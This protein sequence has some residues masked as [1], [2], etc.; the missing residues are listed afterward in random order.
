MNSVRLAGTASFRDP[1]GY[2]V[3]EEDRGLRTVD[4]E[5][6]PDT[7]AFLE[8]SVARDWT[9]SG[10]LVAT[11]VIE[12]WKPGIPLRLAHPRVFFPSYSWEWTPAQ[13]TAAA[14]LTLDFC[15][16]LISAG[17]ILKDATPSNVLF[18]GCKPVFVD[19]LSVQPCDV[20][21]PIWLAY[22]QFVRT[23]LLPLAAYGRWGWPLGS[24][25]GRR[26][27]YEPEELFHLLGPIQRLLRPWRSLVTLPVWLGNRNENGCAHR[28]RRPAPVALAILKRTLKSLRRTLRE[29][30]RETRKSRWS[31]YQETATH[32]SPED[33]NRKAD[34]VSE[35]LSFAEPQYVLDIGSNSGFFSRLASKAGARVIAWDADAA[36]T[37][38]AWLQARQTQADILPLV[39][40]FAR[41]TPAVGWNNAES[42]SLLS[43]SQGRFDMVMMLAVLHHLLIQAQIPMEHVASVTRELTRRWLLIEWVGS[44]DEKFRSLSSGRDSL[45]GGLSEERFI[46]SFSRH[47]EPVRRTVL[48]NGRTLHLFQV[49]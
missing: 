37:E 17:W 38:Q 16:D 19:L 40:D 5:Y 23:F 30:T 31:T 48:A 22:G 41:P 21:N 10:R 44:E 25:V 43:R 45:F 9:R 34:F 12:K 11:E 39:A 26:D 24:M 7:L 32:Y 4:P 36:T 20:E 35:C 8:S 49:K 47:F 1:A 2:L 6:A 29:V 33:W 46:A 3:I 13:L 28:I 14:D 42:L 27:G 18:E 15:E